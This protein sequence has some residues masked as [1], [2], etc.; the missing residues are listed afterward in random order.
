MKHLILILALL[1]PAVAN[2]AIGLTATASVAS[3]NGGAQTITTSA[4]NT[5]GANLLVAITGGATSTN[6]LKDSKGNVWTAV[7]PILFT[8]NSA[9]VNIWYASPGTSQVGS[10][11]TFTASTIGT[12]YWA[13]LVMSFSGASSSPYD[14]AQTTG[15]QSSGTSI[16]LPSLTPSTSGALIV[17]AACLNNTSSTSGITTPTGFNSGPS[18]PGAPVA[19]YVTNSAYTIQTSTTASAPIWN[20]SSTCSATAM[21]VAFRPASVDPVGTLYLSGN[22]ASVGNTKLAGLYNA[23]TFSGS[24]VWNTTGNTWGVTGSTQSGSL[25]L[26]QS[27]VLTSG[28]I[29]GSPGLWNT[30]Q[31]G[32]VSTQG[33][34]GLASSPS[35]GSL[36]ING[37]GTLSSTANTVYCPSGSDVWTGVSTGGTTGSLSLSNSQLISGVTVHS[38]SGNAIYLTGT[39]PAIGQVT[40]NAGSFSL[41]GSGGVTSYGGSNSYQISNLTLS[42]VASGTSFGPSG[43]SVGTNTGQGFNWIGTTSGT[44]TAVASLVKSGSLFSLLGVSGTGT[45]VGGTPISVGGVTITP[46]LFTITGNTAGLSGPLTGSCSATMAWGSALTWTGSNIVYGSGTGYI[47]ASTLVPSAPVPGP[48]MYSTALRKPKETPQRNK[49]ITIAPNG[50]VL[51]EELP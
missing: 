25:S 5:S 18:V 4:I 20:W 22:T 34:Y 32:Y 44:S 23:P 30:V 40:S 49:R 48:F 15:T 9:I 33:T 24:D 8:G 28:T 45:A 14:F 11:H 16:S 42:T 36:T 29:H 43:G 51:I 19:N 26:S 12:I 41:T 37:I 17:T 7:N 31:P 6:T 13:L 46:T 3:P 35:G 10:G 27:L 39:Q 21:Q 50:Q 47:G 1:C 38:V 2:A